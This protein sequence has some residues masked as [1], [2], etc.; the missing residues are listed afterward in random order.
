METLENGI[1]IPYVQVQNELIDD[2]KHFERNEKIVMIVLM[3]HAFGGLAYPSQKSISEKVKFS[4]RTVR[5]CLKGLQ[6]KGFIKNMG[7]HET[8][9]TVKWRVQIPDHVLV[10]WLENDLNRIKGKTKKPEA[11]QA[12]APEEEKK[13]NPLCQQV[14]EYLNKTAEKNYKHTTTNTKKAI[15]ARLSDGF[16][17]KDFIHVI[18]VKTQEWRGTEFEKHLNPET[19]F[20]PANFEKYVN[21]KMKVIRKDY[22][23]FKT[24]QINEGIIISE[25]ERQALLNDL[26]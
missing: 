16:T 1:T 7:L 5:D 20:R 8:M 10:E 2:T 19:L 21:Q 17:I 15:N 14:I 4:D 3:R 9:Q 22:P 11:Q 13:E 18:N 12:A 24:P 6:E 23:T 26:E 25:E